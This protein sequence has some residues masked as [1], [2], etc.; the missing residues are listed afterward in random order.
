MLSQPRRLGFTLVELL[1]VITIIGV[2]I[3]LLL[4]A[5]QA[6][7]EAARRCQCTNNLKQLGLALHSYHDS[8][9][10]FPL[11]SVRIYPPFAPDYTQSNNVTWRARILPFMEQIPLYDKIDCWTLNYWWAAGAPANKARD[12]VRG[13]EIPAFRCPS[14]ELTKP[15]AN[16]APSNYVACTGSDATLSPTISS[17][18]GMFRINTTESAFNSRFVIRIARISDGMSNTMAL[19]ECRT[20]EP[21]ALHRNDWTAC[22]AGTADPA[23]PEEGGSRGHAWMWENYGTTWAYN[24]VFPP[25]DSRHAKYDCTSSTGRGA[26]AARSEHPGG[27]NVTMA[28]GSTRFISETI[29]LATWQG[30]STIAAGEVLGEF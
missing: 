25:N 27:V 5:V 24:A 7:R 1:V 4:P 17:E 18:C 8:H 3:A 11:A 15:V 2:L 29:H 30:L 21:K 20:G 16:W 6:A 23:G 26:Y 9:K 19:S 10:V 12:E 22:I 13:T 14:A 28:D